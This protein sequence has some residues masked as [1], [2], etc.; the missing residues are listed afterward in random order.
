MATSSPDKKITFRMEM[1]F[2]SKT[3][4]LMMLHDV[5][6]AMEGGQPK[7]SFKD[8]GNRYCFGTDGSLPKE[9]R[10]TGMEPGG[11]VVDMRASGDVVVERLKDLRAVLKAQPF[12]ESFSRHQVYEDFSGSYWAIWEEE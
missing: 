9:G 1:G 3:V 5:I 12:N 2:H 4:G 8:E 7:L 10:K 11:L 6:K